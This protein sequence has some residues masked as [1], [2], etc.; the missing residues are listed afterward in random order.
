MKR[1]TSRIDKLFSSYFPSLYYR[2]IQQPKI[3][4]RF[5]IEKKLATGANISN[6]PRPSFIF[7]TTQKCASRYVSEILAS[8]ASSAGIQHADY[9]AYVAMTRVERKENPF[10]KEGTLAVAFKP[11][12]YYYGPIGTYR[13][14]PNLKEYRVLLHLRDPRD[15]LTSLYYSTAYSHAVISPKL[16]RRRKE[17]RQMDVDAFVLLETQEYLP[18][19]QEYCERLLATENVQL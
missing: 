3:K 1:I 17:A 16:V 11:K 12:G 14:I 6:S 18:I 4:S 10:S 5:E 7:F 2:L 19:Y 9:D 8:L 15:V 13:D